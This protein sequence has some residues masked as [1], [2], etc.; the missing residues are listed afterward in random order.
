MFWIAVIVVLLG[1]ITWKFYLKPYRVWRNMGVPQTNPVIFF[2]D[3]WAT[4]FKFMSLPQ[5]MSWIYNKHPE[6]KY[7][8]MYQFTIPVLAVRDPAMIRQLAVKDFDYFTDH[9]SFTISDDI[10]PLWSGN[11]FSLKGQTWRD[12]RALLSGS[13]TSSKMRA[14]YHLIYEEA[15][16]FSE[17][18]KNKNEQLIRLELKDSFTRF[19]NDV[20]A[21]TAFGIKV[22]SLEN[23]D[24][25]F[26]KMGKVMTNFNGFWFLL[27]FIGIILCPWLFKIF[28]ITFLP[29]KAEEFFIKT[30]KETIKVREEQK[31]VRPDMINLLLEVKNGQSTKEENDLVPDTG[32]A[33]VQEHVKAKKQVNITDMDIASQ[34]VIF[35]LA[36]F[37]TVSMAMCYTC[38]ELAINPEIQD[39]LKKEIK[40][41]NERANGKPSYE[42][43]LE[44][45]YLD[46]VISESLRKWPVAPAADRVCV[47]PYTLEP[48]EPYE[49]KIHFEVGMSF[50]IPVYGLHRDPK[51]YP[52]P[53]KFIP[54]RF[55]EENK[56]KLTPYT[57]FPFGVG[58]RAC[59]GSR[60]A[61]LEVKLV[62]F[63]LLKEFSLVTTEETAV[64]LKFDNASLNFIPDGGFPLGL[65]RD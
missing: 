58:P 14:L 6:S 22:D 15:V 47:K 60:F 12:M 51:Y 36:G 11:L 43:I 8:G 16:K 19:T 56:G 45:K 39:K 1:L 9:N 57:Y 63:H 40:E 64:P 13:F 50:W 4:F 25:E 42:D 55:S 65:K 41:T 18:F 28:G 24:N 31:I 20:I 23:P 34:A 46:M 52:E 27:R 38:Y 32:F 54:E 61:L 2:G 7:T 48:T 17:H 59:I 5:W 49:R 3:T 30:I 21:S 53:E 29:G 44:M 33:V 62:L 35:F 10:D 37:D 26:Y